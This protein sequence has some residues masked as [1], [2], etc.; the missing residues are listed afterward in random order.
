MSRRHRRPWRVGWVADVPGAGEVDGEGL[1][2]GDSLGLAI[3]QPSLDIEGLS[4]HHDGGCAHDGE[5]S[6]AGLIM[7]QGDGG[8]H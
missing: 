4:R 8:E 3:A 7:D 6:V 1:A 5:G 2:E